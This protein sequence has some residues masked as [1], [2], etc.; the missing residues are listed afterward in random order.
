MK[1]NILI[2]I[3]E[4]G[5]EVILRTE[6]SPLVLRMSPQEASNIATLLIEGATKALNAANESGESH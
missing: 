3:T 4:D 5:R 1:E 6:K 2:S